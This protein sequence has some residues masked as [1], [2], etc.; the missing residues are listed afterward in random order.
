MGHQGIHD[1]LQGNDIFPAFHQQGRRDMGLHHMSATMM[2]S[3]EMLDV[4][5]QHQNLIREQS[6]WQLAAGGK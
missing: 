5:E 2:L 3:E 6:R 4:T 1:S